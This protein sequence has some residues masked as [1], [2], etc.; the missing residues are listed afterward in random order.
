MTNDYTQAHSKIGP[1]RPRTKKKK[2]LLIFGCDFSGWYS[3]GE[4]IKICHQMSYFK[5]K[6]RQVRFRL[7]LHPRSCWGSYNAPQTPQPLLGDGEG[8]EGPHRGGYFFIYCSVYDL[9]IRF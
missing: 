4:V 5:P 3:F 1:P 8:Q 7:G 6:M 9:C 2:S